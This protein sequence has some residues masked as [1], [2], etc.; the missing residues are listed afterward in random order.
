MDDSFVVQIDD[1]RGQLARVV[2]VRVLI[3]HQVARDARAR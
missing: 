2:T 3:V 1:R